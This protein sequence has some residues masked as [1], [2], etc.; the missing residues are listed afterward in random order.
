MFSTIEGGGRPGG[1][2]HRKSKGG[3]CKA[4]KPLNKNK[5]DVGAEGTRFVGHEEK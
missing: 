3:G 2:N 5:N 4:A 1:L